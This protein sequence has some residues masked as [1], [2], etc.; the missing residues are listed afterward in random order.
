MS[1]EKILDFERALA[2]YTGAP[3]AI[4]TDCCTHAIELCMRHD[5]VHRCMFSAFT[6]LSIP[7]LMHRLKIDYQLVPEKWSG[8]YQFYGTRIYDYARNLQKGMYVPETMQCLSF[9][10]SKPLEIGHGGAILLD[11]T[12][13]YEKLSRMR[14]DGR[15][16]SVLP[17]E[18]Q[19]V[20]SVGYHY[21]PAIEDAVR[22]LELLN[23]YAKIEDHRPAFVQYP[24]CRQ[25]KIVD[26]LDPREILNDR[27]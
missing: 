20:F 16:L 8:G 15:N 10:H 21:R 17:W 27:I 26:S 9:G 4:M 3:Y 7:M 13:T 6:Y 2:D 11:N 23:E 19:K 14:Y 24:D 25:I 5:A 22:G 18:E 1:F 12:K